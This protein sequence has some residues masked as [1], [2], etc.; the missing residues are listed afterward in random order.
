[1]KVW[2]TRCAKVPSKLPSNLL[3]SVRRGY[4]TVP[5]ANYANIAAQNFW[6][7]GTMENNT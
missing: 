4:A 6:I 7:I 2:Y 5:I 1:M 3:V